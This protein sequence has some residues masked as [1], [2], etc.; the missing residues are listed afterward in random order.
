MSIRSFL[1]A[2]SGTTAVEFALTAP[3]FF[4]LV[5]GVIELG[6]VLWMQVT[7]QQGAEAA[8]RCASVNKTLCGSTSQ[9]QSY[10]AAQSYGLS[11]PSS[12]FSVSAPSCGNQVSASYVYNFA[13]GYIGVPKVTLT[14]QSCFPK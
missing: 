11:P 6:I 14:A 1:R 12:T 5:A 2:R 3:L 8:A 9:I 10:A 4:G 13:F 7:L